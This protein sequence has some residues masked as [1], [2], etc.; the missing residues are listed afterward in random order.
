MK[1]LILCRIFDKHNR[2][3]NRWVRPSTDV[4]IPCTECGS[5]V[6]AYAKDAQTL[7]CLDC[8]SCRESSLDQAG[9][10]GET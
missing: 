1:G 9:E 10:G 4:L 8:Y 5:M 7:V 3:V 6:A 2:L